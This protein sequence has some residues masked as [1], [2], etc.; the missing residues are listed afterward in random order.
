MQS[1]RDQKTQHRLTRE[2]SLFSQ[3]CIQTFCLLSL[4]HFKS[5]SCLVNT[6]HLSGTPRIVVVCLLVTILTRQV[7]AW[8]TPSHVKVGRCFKV[9]LSLTLQLLSFVFP[10]LDD[11]HL[12]GRSRGSTGQAAGQADQ[13]GAEEGKTADG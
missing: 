2:R 4:S 8:E 12:C 9:V 3:V 10:G 1:P 6:D 13:R 11:G 7:G 5:G